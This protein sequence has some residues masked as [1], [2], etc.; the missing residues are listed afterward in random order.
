[1]YY[2]SINVVLLILS[3]IKISWNCILCYIRMW[4]YLERR[5]LKMWLWHTLRWSHN[6]IKWSFNSILLVALAKEATEWSLPCLVRG[7]LKTAIKLPQVKKPLRKPEIR[8]TRS[9]TSL[10]ETLGV[11]N[12]NS[13]LIWFFQSPELSNNTFFLVWPLNLKYFVALRNQSIR[14]SVHHLCPVCSTCSRVAYL[15]MI[16]K[17]LGGWLS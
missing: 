6:G 7:T 11:P 8:P 4:Y 13:T 17:L 1:M 10:T 3:L 2:W 5:S 16:G 9:N 12:S 14:E 15:R